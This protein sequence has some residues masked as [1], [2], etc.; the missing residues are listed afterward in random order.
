MTSDAR[1]QLNDSAVDPEELDEWSESFD[2]LLAVV[3]E[4][5]SVTVCSQCAARRG[6]VEDDLREGVRIAGAAV[7]AEQVLAEYFSLL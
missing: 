3:L 6:I 7:F 1:V 2:Q 4:A 5:G